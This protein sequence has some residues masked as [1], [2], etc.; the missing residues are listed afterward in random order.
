MRESRGRD[1]STVD[2][3]SLVLVELKNCSSSS[4]VRR[5]FVTTSGNNKTSNSTL[6]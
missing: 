6:G 4:S 2:E 1:G 5:V 3:E